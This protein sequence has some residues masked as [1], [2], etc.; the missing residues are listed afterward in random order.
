[1]ITFKVFI[2]LL[3]CGHAKSSSQSRIDTLTPTNA[4]TNGLDHSTKSSKAEDDATEKNFECYIQY[5]LDL[6]CQ[7]IP[8]RCFSLSNLCDCDLSIESNSDFIYPCP[9]KIIR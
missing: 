8:E 6:Y 5:D 1:M 3:L 2:L 7:P 9:A 4:S